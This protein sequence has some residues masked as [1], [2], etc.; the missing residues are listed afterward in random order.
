MNG[1][2]VRSVRVDGHSTGKRDAGFDVFGAF[3]EVLAK[4]SD[5]DAALNYKKPVSIGE[6]FM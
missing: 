1:E 6:T 4:C 3:V 5:I 2:L